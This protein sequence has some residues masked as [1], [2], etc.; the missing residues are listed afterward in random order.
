MVGS[1][2]HDTGKSGATKYGKILEDFFFFNICHP[3][4]FLNT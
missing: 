2:V 4:V 1:C 3:E